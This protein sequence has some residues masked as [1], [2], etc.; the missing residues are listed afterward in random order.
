M[1]IEFNSGVVLSN[2]REGRPIHIVD[3]SSKIIPVMFF[4][5]IVSACRD[6]IIFLVKILWC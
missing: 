1:V 6:Y 3:F 2:I 4:L 5:S